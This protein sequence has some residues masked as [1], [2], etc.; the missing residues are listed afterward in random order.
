MIGLHRL[1]RTR[2]LYRSLLPTFELEKQNACDVV[3]LILIGFLAVSVV[4]VFKAR[5][6][7]PSKLIHIHS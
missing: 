5:M 2:W 3:Y 1:A 6:S 7:G 4:V